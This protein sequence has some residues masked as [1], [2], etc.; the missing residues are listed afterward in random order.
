MPIL[1]GVHTVYTVRPGD[2]LYTIASRS[3]SKVELLEQINALYPP[4]AERGVIYPGQV[5]VVSEV[6]LNQ[7]NQVSYII[8]PG[9]SLY[10]IGLRFSAV[11]EMLV[12]LNPLIQN[13]G[14]IYPGVPLIVPAVI[15]AVEE[16][17]SL[18]SISQKLGIPLSE[19]VRANQ[20]R[21]GF[22]PDLILSGYRLIVPLPSSANILVFRPL[23]GAT[24]RPGQA[25][26]GIARAFEAVIQYRLVD[27]EQTVVTEEKTLMTSAGAPA[28]GS[29]STAIQF[30]R[31]PT[32]N[33]GVLWVY[34]RSARDGS[35]IDLVQEQVY[36]TL[37]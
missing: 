25:L 37:S 22:S 3:G 26:E 23:P 8:Y 35:I 30:D 5:L 2:T 13:P 20:G 32:A 19:L 14:V 27:R 11:P 21:P 33:S 16:G 17:E 10:T 7:R 4:F 28:Y 9:D 1:N 24:I 12:G 34:A 31:Q 29:F 15:Y 36:F 18:F 6:G